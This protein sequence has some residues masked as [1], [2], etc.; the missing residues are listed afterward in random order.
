MS[1]GLIL[2]TGSGTGATKSAGRDST[3][4]GGVLSRV[5]GSLRRHSRN[6][7][8][9]ANN[10]ED[11]NWANTYEITHRP[12]RP[13]RDKREGLKHRNST[14]VLDQLHRIW[15][16]SEKMVEAKRRE[17]AVR[18]RVVTAEFA[19]TYDQTNREDERSRQTDDPRSSTSRSNPPNP[20]TDL[21]RNF[22]RKAPSP[23]FTR[24]K[25]QRDGE[26]EYKKPSPHHAPVHEA[27]KNKDYYGQSILSPLSPLDSP[28][29]I[30]IRV[31]LEVQ[32]PETAEGSRASNINSRKPET[33]GYSYARDTSALSPT[34]LPA[35]RSP[36]FRSS[37]SAT[38]AISSGQKKIVRRRHTRT[39]SHSPTQRMAPVS[40]M[41][42]PDARAK[43]SRDTMQLYIYTDLDSTPSTVFNSSPLS[44][45]TS[46]LTPISDVSGDGYVDLETSPIE[47]EASKIC[48]MPLCNN[49]LLTTMDRKQNLCVECRS[50]LQPRQSVFVT[51]VLN[52]FLSPKSSK[53]ADASSSSSLVSDAQYG[54]VIE[55]AE[56]KVEMTPYINGEG[57]TRTSNRRSGRQSAGRAL[58]TEISSPSPKIIINNRYVL[59]RFNKDRGEFR[60][61]PVSP[62]R[63]HTRRGRK[64]QLSH[65]PTRYHAIKQES[66][67]PP[68]D[69][70]HDENGSSHISFQLA[71]WRT[72]TAGS[73][74]QRSPRSQPHLKQRRPSGPLLEPKTFSPVT[75]PKKQSKDGS[76]IYHRRPNPRPRAKGG[77]SGRTSHLPRARVQKTIDPTPSSAP[78]GSVAH[79]GNVHQTNLHSRE[80]RASE[81][82]GNG[83]NTREANKDSNLKGEK[84]L[85]EDEDIYREIESIIDCY[86]RLPDAPES[87][88]EERKAE[89]VASYYATVPLDVRMKIQ[90]FF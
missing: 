66:A 56:E 89:A 30:T 50:E 69:E 54:S 19:R 28:D 29:R 67:R 83:T 86:L 7:G 2:S 71:G 37:Q 73:A 84:K 74:P 8:A 44:E 70:T 64:P 90:G 20:Q 35:P 80:N 14:Y 42:K 24:N 78:P 16:H 63:K 53:S 57:K 72:S 36:M 5:L 32:S 21:V 10:E 46:P 52:P 33:G 25:E 48:P 58:T 38:P 82:A 12:D 41:Q 47:S 39:L 59:S 31:G 60:L 27:D 79:G 17:R 23:E 55:V 68:R 43:A 34:P 61:Q 9:T 85:A 4:S 75:P 13:R 76:G 3:S 11:T 15:R 6:G 1:Q 81:P 18:E 49:P 62:S 22:S 65:L 40:A 45:Q 87:A 26:V 88:N 51:D 77:S